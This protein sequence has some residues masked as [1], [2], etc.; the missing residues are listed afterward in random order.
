MVKSVVVN[1]LAW[2]RKSDLN[3]ADI[4]RIKSLLVRIHEKL[5]GYGGKPSIVTM[6]T[7]TDQYLG[8]PKH[9]IKDFFGNVTID[10]RTTKTRADF[11]NPKVSFRND[12]QRQFVDDLHD[13]AMKN[14]WGGIGQAKGGFGKTICGLLLA[15]RLKMKTLII[16]NKVN[17]ADQWEERI[18]FVFG[19]D[20]KIGRI[21]QDILQTD[22]PFTIAIVKTLASRIKSYSSDEVWGKFGVVLNDECHRLGAKEWASVTMK[23]SCKYNFGLT[24]TPRRKDNLEDVFF[25]LIGEIISVAKIEEDRPSVYR[26]LYEKIINTSAFCNFPGGPIN[27]PRLISHIARD[28]N[29]NDLIVKHLIKA[30]KSG[31]KII[32]LSDR[33]KQLETLFAKVSKE[34]LYSG[35]TCAM[36]CG[37]V[38]DRKKKSGKRTMT[39]EELEEAKKADVIFATFPIAAEGLDI[40]KLD[41]LFLCTPKSDVEQ[42]IYRITRQFEGKKDPMVIDICD[43]HSAF[44][45]MRNSRL[46]YYYNK[47]FEIKDVK[48]QKETR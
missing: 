47:K 30:V 22:G 6:Y 24:A 39:A 8:I 14:G 20:I 42:A 7:E 11:P 29:R 10:D 33:I 9:K 25:F 17:L 12:A 3:K 2:I 16:V 34:V 36:Y 19:K 1:R 23:F 18:R 38:T 21:Q 31:R 27:K 13:G 37:Q 40:P 5:P 15:Y 4:L 46:T 44:K 32:A 26:I 43:T 41:T 35:K 48:M 45:N 28:S